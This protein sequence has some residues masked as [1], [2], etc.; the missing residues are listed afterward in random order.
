MGAGDHRNLISR[1]ERRDLNGTKLTSERVNSSQATGKIEPVRITFFDQSDLFRP[2]PS[3]YLGFPFP[4]RFERLSYF[5]PYEPVCPVLGTKSRNSSRL[6]VLDSYGNVLSHTLV[7]RS[8][9]AGDYVDEESVIEHRGND[10]QS[11][12]ELKM[13]CHW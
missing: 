5:T 9:K 7:D 12:T 13:S 2:T 1:P 4:G 11:A 10:N 6:V 3:L 8:S